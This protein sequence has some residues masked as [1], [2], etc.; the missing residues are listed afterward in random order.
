VRILQERERGSQYTEDLL[1]AELASANLTPEDRALAQE[2]TY[3][4]VRWQA[5]LDWLIAQK[6]PPGRTQKP[7]LQALLRLG[8][9]QLFWL[10]RIPDHAAV[11]ET[12]ALAKQ[13]G[14]EHR[15]GFVNAIL[16]GYLREREATEKQLGHLQR[17]QPAPRIFSPGMA[18][19]PL[20][21]SM[22]ASRRR[23][24]DARQ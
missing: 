9:Y 18:L 23:E 16:R 17:T 5:T 4:A 19:R 11:H 6:T 7:A 8:L 2:L 24:I 13:L 14:F 10:E 15:A 12:V 20:V 1:A 22:G 21:P 3:G